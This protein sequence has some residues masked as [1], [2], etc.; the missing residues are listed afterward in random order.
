LE[1]PGKTVLGFVREA[2]RETKKKF[3]SAILQ[4]LDYYL[5]NYDSNYN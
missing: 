5:D 1:K 3:C 2:A 4:A